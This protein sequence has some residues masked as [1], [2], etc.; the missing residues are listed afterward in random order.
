MLGLVV[1][2]IFFAGTLSRY[3]FKPLNVISKS[4]LLVLAGLTTFLC[5]RPDV[6]NTPLSKRVII[7][8][9]ASIVIRPLWL[10]YRDV[11]GMDSGQN[12]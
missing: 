4:D 11:R 12:A 9:L 3:F 1:A 5:A 6:I 8:I 7:I 10:K 2:I